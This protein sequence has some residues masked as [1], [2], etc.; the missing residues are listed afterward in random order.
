MT[1]DEVIDALRRGETVVIPTDT[2]Y[3]IAVDPT[4]TGA[5]QRLFDSKGRGR[6]VPIAV[7]VADPDQG[8]EIAHRPVPPAALDLAARYWPGALT[9][10]VRRASGWDADLGDDVATVGLRC[11]DHDLVRAWCREVGPLAV[12]SANHHGA[13][14]SA[15]FAPVA[16]MAAVAVD[17][18]RLSGTASTVIDC[19]F[20][21]PRVLRK[22]AIPL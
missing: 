1:D 5:T 21:P 22:G 13:P 15:E 12:T 3:G 16:H 2:V 10:V 4:V 9:I 14:P 17:G 18:G 11:P 20:D 6:E 8:W 7:L 19:T